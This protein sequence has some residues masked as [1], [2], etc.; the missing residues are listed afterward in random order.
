MILISILIV[1][2]FGALGYI[3]WANYV[4]TKT[5]N[6][7]IISNNDIDNDL[8]EIATD[9]SVGTGLAVKYPK[10]WSVSAN[11]IQYDDSNIEII[12]PDGNIAVHLY[13][14][15]NQSNIFNCPEG[16][17]Y[18][19]TQSNSELMPGYSDA[20]WTSLVLNDVSTGLYGYFSGAI[21]AQNKINIGDTCSTA[22]NNT[23]IGVNVK[24]QKYDDKQGYLFLGIELNNVNNDSS[25][26]DI[27]NI[28]KTDNFTTAKR[29]VQSLY[30]K[31]Q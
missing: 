13:T 26:D 14:S 5:Q 20:Q 3:Y 24:N 28:M 8:T 7:I 29:I 23:T 6:S 31:D 30:K 16:S 25:L 18:I 27:D 9:D 17:N 22:I 4:Q 15:I 21:G 10:T 1:V 12:S 11:N 19:V 2:V